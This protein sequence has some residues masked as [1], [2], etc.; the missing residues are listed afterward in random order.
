MKKYIAFLMI[1]TITLM[2]FGCNNTKNTNNTEAIQPTEESNSKP[3]SEC[4][5]IQSTTPKDWSMSGE[6]ADPETNITIV[7]NVDMDSQTLTPENIKIF[8]GKQGNLDISELFNYEYDS[9]TK[10][11]HINFKQEGTDVGPENNIIIELT[12]SVK[13]LDGH[14]LDATY[15]FSYCTI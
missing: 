14:P 10:E 7:F 6:Y 2:S 15:V 1:M 5:I 3:I 12:E 4:N 11:L 13:T 8:D 9:A